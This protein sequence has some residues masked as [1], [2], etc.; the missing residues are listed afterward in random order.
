MALLTE[1]VFPRSRAPFWLLVAIT[2]SGTLAMHILVP[3]LPLA[4]V[5]L[6]VSAGSIQ[7]AITLY[8]VGV[9]FGQL[10]YGPASDMFG[11]RPV[12]LVALSAYVIASIVAGLAP[13]LPVLLAA[14]V[15]QAVGGC[16]GLVLGRA[17]VRDGAEHGQAASQMALL[18]M[19][20]SLA[21]GIGPAIGGYLGAWFGW[22]S[23]FA[24]LT[25]LGGATL[26]AT[27]LTLPETAASRGAA[28]VRMLTSYA[29]LLRASNFRGFMLG[30]AFTSTSIYAYLA[31][32]PFIFTQM[33]HRPA[34]EVGVYYLAIMAGVPVGSFIASRL[35]RRVRL[36]LLLRATNALSMLGAAILFAITISGHL[37]V[38][39][40]LLPMMLYSIGIGATSPIALASAIGTQP[41]MIGA[42]SGLY[43]FT[44]MSFGALCTLAVGVWPGE[45]ALTAAGVLLAA[46]VAGQLAFIAATRVP[47]KLDRF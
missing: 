21:P 7:L 8:L 39:G 47:A 25:G 14:R 11:R 5:D 27:V 17:I 42:A 33:L 2:A 3:S 29:R 13:N 24:A 44:Q 32:S 35:A 26:A 18:T 31:A 36:G 37:S 41:Q 34:E 40:I 9:A 19:T 38:P 6:G 28:P 20:Q 43:G 22:R 12:L 15:V 16:G 10:L 30:G 1:P 46:T 23:I 45:Q 4:A